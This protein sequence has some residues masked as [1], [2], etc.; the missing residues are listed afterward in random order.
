MCDMYVQPS[1]T[2]DFTPPFKRV[3]MVEGVEQAGGFKIPDL[4]SAGT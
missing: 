2:V 4:T 1:V 3:S